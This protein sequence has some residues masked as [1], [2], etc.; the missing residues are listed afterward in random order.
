LRISLGMAKLTNG[1]SWVIGGLGGH[2][3]GSMVSRWLGPSRKDNCGYRYR[4]FTFK[5]RKMKF[6]N[7]WL[8]EYYGLRSVL[9]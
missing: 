7:N 2:A 4:Y 1:S 6:S 9:K 3:V 5:T 8:R